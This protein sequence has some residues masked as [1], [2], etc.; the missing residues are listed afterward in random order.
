MEVAMRHWLSFSWRK[1][2]LRTCLIGRSRSRLA[3]AAAPM[4]EPLEGRVLPSINFNFMEF[5]DP[6]RIAP[7][8]KPSKLGILPLTNGFPF[9]VGY[10][11]DQLRTAYGID[12]VMFRSV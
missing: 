12:K 4:L 11:P 1:R 5:H 9:P 8:L 7:G 2:F 10:T 3:R 6:S